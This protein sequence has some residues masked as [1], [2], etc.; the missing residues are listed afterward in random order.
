MGKHNVLWIEDGAF[1]EVEHM[2][3]PLYVSGKYDLVIAENA[4]EGLQ[5][6]MRTDKKFD[7]IILDIRLPPGEDEKFLTL[8][9]NRKESKIAA[10]LGLSLLKR[11]LKEGEENQ[12]PLHHREAKRFGIF[13]VEGRGELA[14][15]LKELD[16][17]TLKV[18]QKTERNSKDT[19][20]EIIEDIRFPYT[21]GEA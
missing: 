18:Y 12:I 13:T 9:K 6:L 15:D 17:E 1:T 19:L 3:A 8:Y 5:A 21:G 14:H 11:V 7:T 16:L 4:T 2:S 10:R 20:R